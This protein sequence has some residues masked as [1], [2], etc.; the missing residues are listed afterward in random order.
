MM[1]FVRC[2]GHLMQD[3]GLK[4]ILE[5]VYA[6]VTVPHI[7]SGKAIFRAVRAHI[8]VSSALHAHLLGQ[9]AGTLDTLGLEKLQRH[10]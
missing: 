9:D 7:L 2:I 10:P 5:I 4:E 6:P 1:S 8:L 3:S